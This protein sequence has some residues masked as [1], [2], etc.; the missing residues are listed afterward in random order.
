MK[1]FKDKE[2][3][4]LPSDFTPSNSPVGPSPNRKSKY[5]VVPSR[6]ANPDSTRS[7]SSEP[8]DNHSISFRNDDKD[9]ASK[10]KQN[11]EHEMR[12]PLPLVPYHESGSG[13]LDSPQVTP[14]SRLID[15]PQDISDFSPKAQ[16]FLDETK[17]TIQDLAN[18]KIKKE[19]F[20]QLLNAGPTRRLLRWLALENLLQKGFMFP[21]LDERGIQDAIINSKN[22]NCRPA[23]LEWFTSRTW[24]SAQSLPFK[25]ETMFKRA[26]AIDDFFDGVESVI[27]RVWTTLLATFLANDFYNY[28]AYPDERYGAT[29]AG[30]LFSQGENEQALVT[31]LSRPEHWYGFVG[32]LG[33]P[34][35]WGVIKALRTGCFYPP[36]VNVKKLKELEEFFKNYEEAN[37]CREAYEWLMPFSTS[38][39]K[40]E[41]TR[42]ILLWNNQI[43]PEQRLNLYQAFQTFSRH[44]NKF[45]Q[46][47]S[48][49]LLSDIA[50]GIA[51]SDLVRLSRL[52]VEHKVLKSLLAN[53]AHALQELKEWAKN[54]QIL[55]ERGDR[56]YYGRF[57]KP[58]TR[59]LAAQYLLWCLGQPQS[60]WL[61][62]L[63]WG[64]KGAKLLVKVNFAYLMYK[65]IEAAFALYYRKSDCLRDDKVWEFI[66]E[67]GDYN[68]TICADFPI[69]YPYTFTMQSCIDNFLNTPRDPHEIIR[70]FDRVQPRD[71]IIVLDLSN[72]Q[73][74]DVNGTN[75]L[76]QIMPVI[77]KRIST[78]KQFSYDS[79]TNGGINSFPMGPVGGSVIA[80]FLPKSTLQS[81]SLSYNNIGDNGTT[82]IASA[83]SISR[84]QFLDLGYNNIGDSGAAAISSA[85]PKSRLQFLDLGGNNIGDSGAAA[86]GSA[87]PN[88]RLQTLVLYNNRIGPSGAAT[89][90]SAL[91]NSRLQ[92]LYLWGNSIGPSGAATIGS[93]LPNSTLQTLYLS[94]NNIG[95]SGAA[96][97][98]SALPN[99]TLQILDLGSNNIGPS[100]AAAIGA[101][102]PNSTLQSLYLGSNNIG[103][104]GAAIIGSALPNSTLQI[105]DLGSNNI[106]PSGAAAIGSAL[107]NSTLQSLDLSYNN[108][109]DSGAAAI[110]GALPNSRLQTLDFGYNNIGDRGAAA[111]GATL[112]NSTLQS[113]DLSYNNIGDSGA[114]AIV[115]VLIVSPKKAHHLLWIN[116]LDPRDKPIIETPKPNTPL[117]SLLLDNNHINDSTA[118]ALCQSLPWT[119]IP[120]IA[121][122]LDNNNIDSSIVQNGLCVASESSS[123]RPSL[124]GF[125]VPFIV[126]FYFVCRL[127]PFTYSSPTSKHNANPSLKTKEKNEIIP[128]QNRLITQR[129]LQKNITS[130]TKIEI[131][132]KEMQ[133]VCGIHSPY[134]LS[135]VITPLF[136]TRTAWINQKPQTTAAKIETEV[137]TVSQN[138]PSPQ[139]KLTKFN[140]L[141]QYSRSASV[142]KTSVTEPMPEPKQNIKNI[143]D[144]K[145]AVDSQGHL[146]LTMVQ[147][148]AKQ[149]L[150][151]ALTLLYGK[152]IKR[153]PARAI[154]LLSNLAKLGNLEA[155]YELGDCHLSGTGFKQNDKKAA[156]WFTLAAKHGYVL[157]QLQMGY[158]YQ[159]GYGVR[160]DKI[161]AMKWFAKAAKAGDAKA[162]FE[163]AELEKQFFTDADVNL[164]NCRHW[165]MV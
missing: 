107:P 10:S 38:R 158:L 57:L 130:K 24:P 133:D 126:L 135:Q 68:C 128:E 1:V 106:G 39:S 121:L 144:S 86:I 35:G 139:I 62:P 55:L 100:G 82:I 56:S 44:T 8:S 156:E 125:A 12:T 129:E 88:S 127:F 52:G 72:Q 159:G 140:C 83:M 134:T 2:E 7:K 79:Y 69:P 96:A 25:S 95:D 4:L 91:P 87:L 41:A 108:I 15:L 104:S 59:Y 151:L 148:V 97:I 81:L 49:D 31:Y 85:L 157:A 155:M 161:M 101:A 165:N 137:E 89:I 76:T 45:A 18:A 164:K 147:E 42:Q 23:L 162:Q 27:T 21:L 110:S 131:T 65:G 51:I 84:L 109:D 9:K 143:K 13:P 46:S 149:Q 93:A 163:L 47:Y 11:V 118:E 77:Q 122:N 117:T 71:N 43:T 36:T 103:P 66:N 63:F 102:L 16:T 53:K 124:L 80:A 26:Y 14:Y 146:R 75:N 94:Y 98:S 34:L 70:L 20:E 115:D 136:K 112:P 114:K 90:G 61:Q 30:I 40:L 67:I 99:S 153:D 74:P 138:T 6:S 145:E 22:P 29:P 160:E 141:F 17:L 116:L 113:L 50:D 132:A 111:I 54:Y 142:S 28:Y 58:L 32:F 105:L 78:L 119:H 92:T 152:N 150:S 64:F 123:I 154:E 73:F 5:A 33:I 19:T 48:L 37:F 120:N 3:P 60:N